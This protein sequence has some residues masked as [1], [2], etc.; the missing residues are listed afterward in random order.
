MQKVSD[1][2]AVVLVG[3]MG[4]RL[5]SVVSDRPKVMAEVGGRPFLTYLLD[6][7]RSAGFS[8]V[9]LCCGYMAEGVS[10]YFGDSYGSL[11]IIYSNEDHPLGTGGALRLALPYVTS[12]VVLVMNGDSYVDADLGEFIKWFNEKRCQAALILTTADDT[13]RYGKIQINADETIE[14][15]NEKCDNSGSGW[16]NAG[17]Y[18]IRRSSIT[19]IPDGRV[20]SLERDFF[21]VLAGKELA[22]FRFYGRFIDIGTPQSYELAKGFF[23]EKCRDGNEVS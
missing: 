2:N 6:Q 13:S 18:L 8:K 4:T 14:R 12:E 16:I 1:I 20:F 19:S 10:E 22:G 21:P 17:V 11:R 15:F 5:R 23:N 7:L 3:G 9:I